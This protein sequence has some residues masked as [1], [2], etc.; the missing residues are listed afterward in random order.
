MVPPPPSSTFTISMRRES[1]TSDIDSSY[2]AN[3]DDEF[4][5]IECPNDRSSDSTSDVV[6]VGSCEPQAVT[7]PRDSSESD[8]TMVTTEALTTQHSQNSIP[9]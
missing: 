1:N 4:V 2:P 3:S 9:H 6:V 8:S 5:V 7:A